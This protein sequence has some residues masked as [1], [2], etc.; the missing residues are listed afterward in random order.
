MYLIA[1][2]SRDCCVAP[3]VVPFRTV[4]LVVKAIGRLQQS[5]I[6]RTVQGSMV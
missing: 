5:H 4:S 3:P 6:G 1:S 2:G